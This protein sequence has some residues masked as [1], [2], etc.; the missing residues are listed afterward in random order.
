M[1]FF[2]LP[3]I[4][5]KCT[6]V[7]ILV[8][9]IVMRKPHLY[10]AVYCIL[11]DKKWQI[12]LM[13]RANTWYYDWWWSLPA[14]HVEKGEGPISCLRHEMKEELWITPVEYKF[15]HV[16]HRI[17]EDR[18]YVDYWFIISWWDW[19]ITNLEEDKCSA[20]ER[21]NKNSLP[22]YITPSAVNF[23]SMLNEKSKF[24]EIN[25]TK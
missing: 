18:E 8:K 23:I 10:W 13:Q 25:T 3:W 5:T 19:E 15:F 21:F 4:S 16:I 7:R 17:D 2:Y 1:E 24:S 22:E 12:L 20:L 14:W 9:R 6:Y 11:Q